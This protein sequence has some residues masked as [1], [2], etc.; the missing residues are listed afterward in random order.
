[1]RHLHR[2]GWRSE[3]GDNRDKLFRVTK[4]VTPRK[5]D[6]RPEM[7]PVYNQGRL[8]SCV[9]NAIGAAFQYKH[10]KQGLEDF[11]PSRLF[12]YYNARETEGTIDYDAGCFIRDGIKSIVSKGSCPEPVWP[13][14]VTKFKIKPPDEAYA[15]AIHHTAAR[16]EKLPAL[17]GVVMEALAL[18][19]PVIFGFTVYESFE[20]AS[21]ANTGIV[22]MPQLTERPLGGHAVLAVGYDKDQQ[23]FIVRNSWGDWGDK[24]HCYMPFNYLGASQA[25]DF[26]VVKRVR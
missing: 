26:W 21:V 15:A 20:S 7:P 9:A 25:R 13:Y 14:L 1:M 23:H 3:N 11:I 6:L 16:Y 4:D 2:Y 19:L 24:G 10:V 8:G 17:K 22:P 5:I 18:K 12:T